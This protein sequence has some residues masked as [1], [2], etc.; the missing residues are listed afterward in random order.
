[1][2]EYGFKLHWI[3]SHGQL[4][5]QTDRKR[6]FRVSFKES[7]AVIKYGCDFFDTYLTQKWGLYPPSMNQGDFMTASS[8]RLWQ[9]LQQGHGSA[10]IFSLVAETLILAVLR[11]LVRSLTILKSPRS[12]EDQ[13]TWRCHLVGV[14]SR[15]WPTWITPIQMPDKGVKKSPDYS[16]IQSFESFQLRP[17]KLWKWDKPSLWIPDL[18]SSEHNKML[19]VLD[20]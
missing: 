15:L 3:Y 11:P 14:Q 12:E 6:K 10:F 8:G 5:A 19:V 7:V 20:H 9:N 18:Q 4:Y 13:V 17:Q 2:Q 1:M 16:S